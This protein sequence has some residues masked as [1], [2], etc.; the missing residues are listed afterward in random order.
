MNMKKLRYICLVVL[1]AFALMLES[2]RKNPDDNTINIF[3]ISDDKSLGL[4]VKE[5]IFANPSEYPVLDTVRYAAAY[6]YLR[7]IV[8]KIMDG[9]KVYYKDDFAWETYIIHDD[10]VLNAF[11]TPGGYIFVYTGLIKYLDAEHELAGVMGHEIAHADRRHT[12]DAMTRE[13]G[14]SVLLN[15]AFGK[16]PTTL[17]NITGNLIALKYS[18]NAETE[19][20]KYSVVYLCPTDYRANGAAGFFQKLIDAGD[21]EGSLE[22]FSTHPS[23][24]NRVQRIN[25]EKEELSCSGNS[26]FDSA[27]EEFKSQLP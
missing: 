27:Y 15:V 4:Q 5:E 6:A 18:R 16:D 21:G 1:P 24:D 12:T 14:L 20:D 9:G 17:K 7:G 26:T 13:Y 10:N 22:W 11:C 2:C 23:P 8:S 25:S 19:A 3:S